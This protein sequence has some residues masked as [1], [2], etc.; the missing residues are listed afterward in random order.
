[1]PPVFYPSCKVRVTVRLET[2]VPEVLVPQTFNPFLGPEAFGDGLASEV[3]DLRGDTFTMDLVPY[4]AMVEMNSYRL[5]DSASF[6]VPFMRLPLDP[7]IVRAMAVQIFG[8]C[9]LPEEFAAAMVPDGPGLL[10]P[11]V[12]PIASGRPS[13]GQS[14]E[15][16]RGFADLTRTTLNGDRSILRVEARDTTG[17]LLDAEVPPNVLRDIPMTLPLDQVIQLL[18]TGDGVPVKELSRRFGLPGM[19]GIRVIN[20]TGDDELTIDLPSIRDSRSLGYLSSAKTVKKSRKGRGR[21]TKGSKQTYW[22]L[23]T[24]LCV[25]A[26]YIVYIRAGTQSIEVPGV[27]AVLPAAEIVISNPRTYYG[28]D[29]TGVDI[30]DLN[31]VRTFIYGINA[32]SMDVERK[33][34]GTKTPSVEVSAMDVE[35][36]L[37]LRSR[38][39]PLPKN[40]RPAVGLT[41]DREEVKQFLL[42]EIGGPRA[43]ERLLDA[44]KSIY[45]QLGRG[46]MRVK[47]TTRH[48]A[49]Y[50]AY[51]DDGVE[52]DL[53]QLR[54]G[55]SIMIEV[56]RSAF[57]EG[58]IPAWALFSTATAPERIESMVAMGIPL[59]IAARIALAMDTPF[60]QKV[61]RVVRNSLS[62]D[63]MRGWD[64]SIEAVNYLDVRSSVSA[65]ET[66]VP[67]P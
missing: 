23:I 49:A 32:E 51:L 53:F 54:A 31:T 61:F 15:L 11:D 21:G 66:G 43:Q 33:L 65:I 18:L 59:I 50:L 30:V 63:H 41:G 14:N 13:A 7:R 29:S 27:G 17:P 20:E 9:F 28:S 6:E 1:M 67:S 64:A 40:N 45:E 37:L 39:P 58:T 35:T 3:L 2:F 47:I 62:F 55:D 4:T 26:G 12:V 48:L 22:D 42:R 8:G 44:A 34:T 60:L 46:E 10:L 52:A 24:D 56:L 36:G 19:R 16:F 5:A 38:F 25:N 57:G